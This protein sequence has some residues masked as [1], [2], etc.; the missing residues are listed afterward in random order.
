MKIVKNAV[1][2]F[3]GLELTALGTVLLKR[4]NLG[5]NSLSTLPA[6]LNGIFPIISFGNA[7]LLLMILSIV[8]LVLITR[9]FKIDYLFCFI[10]SIIY[11]VLVDITGILFRGYETDMMIRIILFLIGM[12]LVSIGIYLQKET[13]LPSTPFNVFCKDLACYLNKP[14]STLKVSLDIL[15]VTIT[16]VLEIIIGNYSFVGIGTVICALSI[17]R[18]VGLYQTKFPLNNN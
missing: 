11:S 10:S 7:N 16:L 17:G 5:M 6:I 1:I 2:L 4:C 15:F 14:F 8:L 18:L 9:H 12:L 13:E 3:A